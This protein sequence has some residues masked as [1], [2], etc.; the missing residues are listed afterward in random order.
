MMFLSQSASLFLEPERQETDGDPEERTQLRKRL[1]KNSEAGRV[2]TDYFNHVTSTPNADQ[3]ERL[4]DEVRRIPGCEYY[5]PLHVYRFFRNLRARAK[6]KIFDCTESAG[7]LGSTGSVVATLDRLLEQE[8]DL[9]PMTAEMWTT[10]IGQESTPQANSTCALP[11][12]REKTRKHERATSAVIMPVIPKLPLLPPFRRITTP[13]SAQRFQAFVDDSAFSSPSSPDD[14]LHG[15]QAISPCHQGYEYDI[16]PF[17]TT[18]SALDASRLASLLSEALYPL[19]PVE[20]SESI[21]KTFAELVLWLQ[22]Q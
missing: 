22:V 17:Y 8:P 4:A 1:P 18:L 15:Q 14:N 19:P 20:E 12:R 21:P 9:S 16:S 13:H 6:E 3:R 5:T 11:K 10:K 7:D 2:L